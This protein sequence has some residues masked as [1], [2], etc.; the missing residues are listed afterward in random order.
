MANHLLVCSYMVNWKCGRVRFI[1]PVL[2]TDDPKGSVSSNLTAS[3]KKIWRVGRVAEDTFLLRRHTGKNLYHW[4]KSN[5]LRQCPY[6]QI[7]KVGS[8]KR[9]SSLCSNQSRGTKIYVGVLLN[10]QVADCKSV[11]CRFDSCH[12][13]QVCCFF[14][15]R[16]KSA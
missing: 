4:F 7:G 3:A 1:A 6:G 14:A 9:S 16:K 11:L 12:P 13:L 15:T 10:G 2:K 5:T 8:L